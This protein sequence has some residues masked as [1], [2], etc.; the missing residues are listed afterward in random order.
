M[1]SVLYTTSPFL[2]QV[3]E[4]E[5]GSIK[6]SF[7]FP[8]QFS[9]FRLERTLSGQSPFDVA[10][11][12]LCFTHWSPISAGPTF[13]STTSPEGNDSRDLTLR[14]QEPLASYHAARLC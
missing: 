1:V 7:C 6:R 2:R 14:G 5:L 4:I 10:M 9:S 3:R 11:V 13:Q 12:P 8:F